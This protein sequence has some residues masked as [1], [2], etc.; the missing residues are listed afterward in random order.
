MITIEQE[1]QHVRQ[2][3]LID[4]GSEEAERNGTNRKRHILKKKSLEKTA[5]RPPMPQEH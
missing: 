3:R 5:R 1:P 2:S 4:V